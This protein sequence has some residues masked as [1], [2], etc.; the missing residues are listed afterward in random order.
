MFF[1]ILLEDFIYVRHT[2]ILSPNDDGGRDQDT[3]DVSWLYAYELRRQEHGRG[4][5]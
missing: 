1:F 4:G 5:R 2:T 3:S